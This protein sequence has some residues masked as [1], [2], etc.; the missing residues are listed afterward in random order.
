M[1]VREQDR[2]Y[3][4]INTHRGQTRV[5]NSLRPSNIA[6]NHGY[7]FTRTRGSTL[8]YGGYH[9]NR[10]MA[11]EHLENLEQVL[12]RLDRYGLKANVA[13]SEF[14]KDKIEFCGHVIDAKPVTLATDASPY[15]LGAVLFHTMP[16]GSKKSIMFAS[17]SLSQAEKNYEQIDKEA[18]GLVWGVKKFHTYLYGKRFTLVTDHQ[19]LVSI[20]N[21][22]KGCP[23]TTAA[24][25][26]RY[27]LFLFGFQYDIRYK[28]TR[29]H[30]NA[31][32]LTRLLVPIGNEELNEESYDVTELYM[33]QQLDSL[34]VSSEEI[35][36]ETVKD[37]TLKVV[38]DMTA[39]G[40]PASA[41]NL[42]KALKACFTRRNEISIYQG[43]LL[44]GIRVIVLQN[45]RSR[46]LEE[47]HEGHPVI[48]KMQTAARSLV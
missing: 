28:N 11:E 44:W 23:V 24:R 17:R 16:D 5:L 43:W 38:Y 14:M 15:G 40:W 39:S 18:L 46:V 4:T 29:K 26:Q 48:V 35:Q 2:P 25:L 19:P 20:F 1:T 6:E 33:I 10:G 41:N 47:L 32:A 9:H 27:T 34:P 22:E 37:T 7:S 8:Q 12:K 36:R 21:P 30:N 45:I 31:D 3:L 42:N 13:M